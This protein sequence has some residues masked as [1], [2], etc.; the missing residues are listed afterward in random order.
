VKISTTNATTQTVDHQVCRPHRGVVAICRILDVVPGDGSEDIGNKHTQK[1][2]TSNEDNSN[3]EDDS[4]LLLRQRRSRL[5]RGS[6]G[7]LNTLPF[8]P[9]HI[10]RTGDEEAVAE[11][12]GGSGR[13]RSRPHRANPL[14]RPCLHLSCASILIV[15]RKEGYS[16]RIDIGSAAEEIS[17]VGIVDAGGRVEKERVFMMTE[18]HPPA[19]RNDGEQVG[20]GDGGDV[21][22][23]NAELST[24]QI[25]EKRNTR[26]KKWWRWLGVSDEQLDETVS[27][28]EE[29]LSNL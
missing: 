2:P 17:G 21:V 7:I 15:A 16:C 19:D 3:D 27:D 24:Q 28:I 29:G 18:G 20:S 10:L 12:G 5:V 26:Y 25:M 4:V 9:D 14:R 22:T 6:Y 23:N 13:K 8:V 1:Y 11:Y